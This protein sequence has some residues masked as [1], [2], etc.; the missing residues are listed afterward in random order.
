MELQRISCAELLALFRTGEVSPREVVAAY[1]DRVRQ[2]EKL[3][4]YLALSLDNA[5]RQAREAEGRYRRGEARELEGLGFAVKDLIDT[6][7]LPTTRGSV[8]FRSRVPAADA[9]AVRRLQSAGAILLGKTQTHEF[10][11]G[12]TSV[13]RA[14]GSARN[15]WDPSRIA[16]GSSGGSAVAVASQAAAFAL[17]TDT[18]GSTRLPASFCGVVGFKPTWGLTSMEGVMPLAPSLD[19]L[20]L[21]ARTPTD[22]AIVFDVLIEPPLKPAQG[23]TK[24]KVGLVLDGLAANDPVRSALVH[25]AELLKSHGAEIQEYPIL[26]DQDALA[27]FNTIQRTEALASHHRY[28]I[29][30]DHLESYGNDVRLHFERAATITSEEIALAILGRE[31]LRCKLRAAFERFDL[32][33]SPVAGC[34]PPPFDVDPLEI[35]DSILPYTVAQNLT[36]APACVIRA[37][38]SEARLPVGLQLTMAPGRDHDLLRYAEELAGWLPDVQ[39]IDPVGSQPA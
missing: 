39:P 32:I 12:I 29:L 9:D 23:P 6:R 30:P 16:G 25:A 13:N 22:A 4:A 34:E 15:P 20:G 5:E 19:H 14:M 36:G 31:Q 24:H 2:T 37:G 7:A 35:R 3:G 28:E 33:L 11:W 1:G 27:S 38:F 21:I 8:L 10:G 17:G 26:A 18:G